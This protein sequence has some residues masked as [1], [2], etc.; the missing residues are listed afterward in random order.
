[1]L[2]TTVQEFGNT[3]I[4]RCRGRIV[5][6]EDL[7][8]LRRAA[9]GYAPART[10]VLDLAGVERI[11]AG[12]LGALLNLREWVL[13]HAIRFKL[14]NVINDVDRVIRLTKLDRVFEFWSICDMLELAH[15]AHVAHMA[16]I[17]NNQECGS[18]AL[19]E[20]LAAL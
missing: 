6:G 4:V 19:H 3:T 5:V 15:L 9:L 20:P 10:V 7:A 1:M 8:I 14:M 13:S 12:G 18:A 11:D 16:A 2:K 17:S